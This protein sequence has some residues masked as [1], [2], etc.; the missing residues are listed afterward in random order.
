M[1]SRSPFTFRHVVDSRHR[2]STSDRSL[3]TFPRRDTRTLYDGEEGPV[4][5][6]MSAENTVKDLV[7]VAMEIYVKD[8]RRP[9]LKQNDPDFFELHYS[10]FSLES[11]KPDE[12]LINLGSRNFFLCSKPTNAVNWS[13]SEANMAVKYPFPLTKLMDFLL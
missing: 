6:I 2:R 13:C 7:K 1:T 5:V 8:K 3:E 11:L 12:K 9:L 4:H 10:Q